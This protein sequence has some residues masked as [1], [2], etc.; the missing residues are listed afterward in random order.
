MLVPDDHPVAPGASLGLLVTDRSGA[1]V[2]TMAARL[3]DF[4]GTTLKAEVDTL[5]FYFGPRAGEMRPRVRSAITAPT[6]ATLAEPAVYLG[7]FWL[8]PRVRGAGL[9]SLIPRIMRYIALTT[10]SHRIE[11]SLGRNKFL[12]PEVS[13]T[14]TFAHMETGFD[15]YQDGTLVWDGVLLWSTRDELTAQLHAA[16][17]DAGDP[18]AAQWM[19]VADS[20]TEPAPGAASG[21]NRR[22]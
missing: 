20:A 5:H 9:S 8:H 19:M 22:E 10:W 2:S 4:T 6:A 1:V 15:F 11:F 7:G 3:F 21:S 13:A 12:R 17:A 18:G 14:Y 16:L